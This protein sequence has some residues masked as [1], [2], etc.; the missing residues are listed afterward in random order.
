MLADNQEPGD[1]WKAELARI[2]TKNDPRT[3]WIKEIGLHVDLC[4]AQQEMGRVGIDYGKALQAGGENMELQK[5]YAGAALRV[6]AADLRLEMA[7]LDFEIGKR[8]GFDNDPEL[9]GL[10]EKRK[11]L[12]AELQALE[13][14][15][16]PATQRG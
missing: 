9:A 7:D 12:R 1:R 10:R 5:G 2:D 15:T 14:A 3:D 11:Q 16:R 13:A 6:R 8:E 4:D